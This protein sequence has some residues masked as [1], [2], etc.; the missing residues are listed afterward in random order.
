MF[1]RYIYFQQHMDCTLIGRKVNNALDAVKRT[2]TEYNLERLKLLAHIETVIDAATDGVD[3]PDVRATS[4]LRLIEP[5]NSPSAKLRSMRSRSKVLKGEGLSATDRIRKEL[6]STKA[7][8]EL[9]K[10]LRKLT[11]AQN[12]LKTALTPVELI[13]EANAVYIDSNVVY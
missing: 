1:S 4:L 9:T 7:N 13:I 8:S 11:T 6:E 2:A 3:D 12:N 10:K 5:M